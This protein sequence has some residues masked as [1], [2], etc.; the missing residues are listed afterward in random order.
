M[1][2]TPR[3][4]NSSPLKINGWKMNFLLGWPICRCDLSFREGNRSHKFTR[5][6]FDEKGAKICRMVVNHTWRAKHS[7][8][9]PVQR[10]HPEATSIFM[11]QLVSFA[12]EI[13][14]ICRFETIPFRSRY[15]IP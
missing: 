5:L 4:T 6:V 15:R 8:G 14:R 9:E 7:S 3:V 11:F 10:Q 1:S 12:G 13:Q 2:T